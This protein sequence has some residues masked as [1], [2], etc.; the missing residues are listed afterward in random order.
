MILLGYVT[1]SFAI[2]VLTLSIVALISADRDMSVA[3]VALSAIFI[4]ASATVI[5]W[6]ILTI[7]KLA[8]CVAA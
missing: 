1:L 7:I 3:G 8:L 4:A 2:Y 6:A 5:F